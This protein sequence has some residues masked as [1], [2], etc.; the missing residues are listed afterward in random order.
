M[1]R[2]IRIALLTLTLAGCGMNPEPA[3]WGCQIEVQKGNAGKSAA[4]DAER[5]RDIDA[6]MREKGY[7]L[8]ITN[9]ACDQGA[10]N[11]S[12]YVSR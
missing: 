5:S 7:R 12:C 9:P 8:D 4:A 10:V 11:S 1:P 2:A 3:L 6:C